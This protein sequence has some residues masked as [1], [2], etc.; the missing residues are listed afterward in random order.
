MKYP[1]GNVFFYFFFYFFIFVLH[2]CFNIKRTLFI[3]SLT[4][5]SGVCWFVVHCPAIVLTVRLFHSAKVNLNTTITLLCLEFVAR[6]LAL[7]TITL[8]TV[9]GIGMQNSGNGS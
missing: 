4:F 9:V 5:R 8:D 2:I 6:F 3:R 1:M 7:H